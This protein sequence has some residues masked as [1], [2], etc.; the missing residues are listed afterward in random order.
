MILTF[1]TISCFS[2]GKISFLTQSVILRNNKITSKKSFYFIGSPVTGLEHLLK[3][4]FKLLLL[5]QFLLKIKIKY[6]NVTTD[7]R[8]HT[9]FVFSIIYCR[10]KMGYYHFGFSNC[11]YTFT[12]ISCYWIK[13]LISSF[14]LQLEK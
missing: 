5:Y 1:S 10:S 8:C 9:I 2:L 7:Y 4:T 3:K 13:L 11:V 6:V 12:T 14:V